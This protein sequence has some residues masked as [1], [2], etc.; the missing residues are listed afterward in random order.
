M[1]WLLCLS[2]GVLKYLI[3]TGLF[4]VSL[5]YLSAS[6]ASSFLVLTPVFGIA[7]AVLFLGERLSGSQLIGVF[8]VLIFV[9]ATQFAYQHPA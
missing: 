5:R 3:A 4:F 9:S 1:A 6:F 2:T 8:I 7:A